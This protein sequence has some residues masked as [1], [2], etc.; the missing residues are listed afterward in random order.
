LHGYRSLKRVIAECNW[1][2][3]AI[4]EPLTSK[5]NLATVNPYTEVHC[6]QTYNTR[7]P[8]ELV[9]MGN[10]NHSGQTDIFIALI[11]AFL[12]NKETKGAGKMAQ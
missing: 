6:T 10:I 7:N 3:K 4:P 11:H 8:A 5:V 12:N 1:Q 9:I 2:R